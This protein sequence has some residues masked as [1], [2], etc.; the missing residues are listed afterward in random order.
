MHLHA[1]ILIPKKRAQAVTLP[2]P[3]S[4]WCPLYFFIIPRYG[5]NSHGHQTVQSRLEEQFLARGHPS[6]ILG[7]NLG[8]NKTSDNAIH[9]YIKGV[10]CF[11]GWG[12]Y[13]VINV[14]SPNTAGLRSL[15]GR[16]QLTKLI[17]E[18]TGNMI[19]ILC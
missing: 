12:D 19:L 8:K 7:I 10:R 1:I 9:D 5:F 16:E 17:D 11:S 18:V 14:S 3:L 4:P 15:Q 2:A 13:L 6:G